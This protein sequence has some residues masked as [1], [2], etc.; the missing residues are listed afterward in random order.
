MRIGI[1]GGTFDPPHI[2]HQILAAEALEQLKL[3]QVLWLLTPH[4]PHKK[5]RKI[6]PIA[7][8]LRMVEL[9]IKGDSKFTLSRIDIDR[10]PPH[11]AVDTM[12]LL[13]DQAPG[14]EFYYLMGLDSL[15]DLLTWHR[16]ANFVELC[17][18]IAVMMRQGDILNLSRQEAKIPGL[19]AKLHLLQTP[20]IE[21]SAKEIRK[22]VES[23]EQYRYFLPEKIYRY[24]ADNRLYLD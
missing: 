14:D 22:R 1:L 2:G 18:G 20:I 17:H 7:H 16:P 5:K 24:I 6:T 8:R 19:E 10:Q 12:S 21:I 13:R 4:P 11:Y 3:D 23:G 9:A 15:N